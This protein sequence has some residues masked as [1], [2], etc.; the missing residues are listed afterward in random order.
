MFWSRCIFSSLTL[1]LLA[2]VFPGCGSSDSSAPAQIANSSNSLRTQNVILITVDGLRIQEMF[3]GMDSTIIADEDGSG[4]HYSSEL[5][6]VRSA[7]WRD[8]PEERRLALMPF[9]WSTLA[10]NGIV[11]G[12]KEKGSRVLVKNNQL[13]SAP[14]YV[15]ILTGRP[16]PEVVSNDLIRYKHP[17]VLQFVQQE[18]GL[19]WTEVASIGGW[20]GYNLLASSV[21]NAFFTNGGYERVPAEYSTPRM[22]ELANLQDQIMTLWPETRSDAVTFGIALEYLK[23]HHPRLLYLALGESDDWSH[24]RRY[25]RLLDYIHVFDGYLKQLWEFLQ[26]SD[27][28]RGRTTLVLTTDHGRGIKPE[29]WVGHGE[30][31]AG[32]E[33]IWI[34]VIGPDTPRRGEMELYPDVF[35]S[36]VAATVA[37]FFGLDYSKQDSE[38]GP[39]IPLAFS[40]EPGAGA[41][42]P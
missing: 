35:Q 36:D 7:F 37:A 6:R 12:N 39:P 28:Y 13:F 31:I 10:K 5:E 21:E 41:G 29:D 1:V 25:D 18:L 26:A 4:I 20:E 9:F 23:K 22:D 33:D 15:E 42:S 17:T 34:A 32:A 8:T 11:L 27:R 16:W 24:A 14:G 40:I 3:G 2:S 19:D 38:A 30:G